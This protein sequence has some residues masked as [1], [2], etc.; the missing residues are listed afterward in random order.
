MQHARPP[1]PSPTPGVH[2]NPRP[3]SQGYHL[4]IS[5]SVVPSPPALNLSQHQGIFKWVSSS[6]SS[7]QS[8]GISAS[9]SALPM[10]TQDWSPLGWTG[11]ISLQ[12]KGLSRVFP[13]TTAQKHQL[14]GAQ[15]S[16]YY[17]S[18]IHAW[19]LENHSLDKMD[20]RW[21]SNVWFLICCLGWS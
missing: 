19:L 15:P 21:H 9:T 13:N 7:G 18:H 10:N 6:M 5:S 8:A 14:C 12:S 1:W 4:T 20:L 17:S 3:L 16:L 11:L 2:P